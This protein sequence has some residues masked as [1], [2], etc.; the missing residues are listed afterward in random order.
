MGL[1]KEAIARDDLAR[2]QELLI[3][4]IELGVVSTIHRLLKPCASARYR[5]ESSSVE[6]HEKCSPSQ[7]RAP[8]EI[9]SAE[10]CNSLKGV[11]LHSCLSETPL[12]GA[13]WNYMGGT[14]AQS[15]AVV[16][17]TVQ[18]EDYRQVQATT[19]RIL[20]CLGGRL[21]ARSE[22]LENGVLGTAGELF[23]SHSSTQIRLLASE[24]LASIC[25][26]DDGGKILAEAGV[27]SQLV[28]F[29]CVVPW[30]LPLPEMR[31]LR[32]ST[33]AA[34]S[35]ATV[36]ETKIRFA[37]TSIVP[38]A[39]RLLRLFLPK[40]ECVEA[41]HGDSVNATAA[42]AP[43]D[44]LR[45]PDPPPRQTLELLRLLATII[46]DDNTAD[47]AMKH[48][49]VSVACKYIPI[50]WPTG[51]HEPLGML[52]RLGCT[53]EGLKAI[54]NNDDFLRVMGLT[55]MKPAAVLLAEAFSRMQARERDLLATEMDEPHDGWLQY[56]VEEDH[57]YKEA[58]VEAMHV[59]HPSFPSGK[60][61]A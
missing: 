14:N 57:E 12:R 29:L 47:D 42:L 10:N 28:S 20:K 35:V 33:V 39:A 32:N 19:L 45:E 16:R 3:Q 26:Y 49:L 21:S 41:K 18:G 50:M 23:I 46:T 55:A 61:S 31:L 60:H 7:E 25:I 5:F 6:P 53:E 11:S 48:E 36:P 37:T 1:D 34:C 17:N 56:I 24:F 13:R 22:M 15:P 51:A 58:S 52:N 38:A 43:L 27:D 2:R 4:A 40:L 59:K 54:V 8:K 9:H 44:G 30:H